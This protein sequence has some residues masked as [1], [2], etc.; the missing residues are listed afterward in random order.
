MDD[1]S[2]ILNQLGEHRNEYSNAVT[3]PMINS[4]NFCFPT[5]HEMRIAVA[6]EENNALYTRGKNPTTDILNQKL[7]ALEGT[8]AAL[9]VSSGSAAVSMAVLSIVKSG[10]HI[11]CIQNPYSWTMRLFS[12]YLQ[13]FNISVTYVSGENAESYE[14]AIQTNTTLFY[15]ESPNSLTFQIQDIQSIANLAKSKGIKT[16]IDNS[17]SSPLGTRPKE[18]GIDLIVHAATKY[19]A[20]HSDCVAGVIM[21]NRE[22]IS[23]IFYGEF[24]TL[25]AIIS[26]FNSWLLLRSLRTLEIRIERIS[27]TTKKIIE[28]LNQHEAIEAIYYPH[29]PSNP[30]Y[31]LACKQMRYPMGLFSILLTTK[32]EE[33]I[34]Q[35]CESLKHFLMAVS[36][37]GYESLIWPA[38][39]YYDIRK[40][41]LPINLIRV[42][43]GLEKAE[44]LI[45]DLDQA[46]LKT[47]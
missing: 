36:W 31:E 35:F 38:I 25:G 47:L 19:L 1:L 7:A 45:S 3:P 16:I 6:D 9:T 46:L 32:N 41:D 22:D 4:S 11:V 21:G 20:G 40:G 13:R 42:S 34:I 14:K 29:L 39:A 18:L 24:M 26:P 2:F 8:D 44:D 30:D 10:D 43:I 27:K 12:E 17:Y 5:V 37:G 15:L 23:R 28:F 33:K